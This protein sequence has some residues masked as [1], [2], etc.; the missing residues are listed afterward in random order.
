[1][2]SSHN[3]GHNA[4]GGPARAQSRDSHPGSAVR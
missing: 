1:M 2:T 4:I 3:G